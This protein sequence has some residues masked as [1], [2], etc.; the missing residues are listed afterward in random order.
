M[1]PLGG[2]PFRILVWF[3]IVVTAGCQ[4]V[5]R[6]FVGESTKGDLT[7]VARVSTSAL[8]IEW[9]FRNPR[10][11]P[12]LIATTFADEDLNPTSCVDLRYWKDGVL[13]LALFDPSP[14]SVRLHLLFPD[15]PREHEPC[16]FLLFELVPPRGTLTWTTTVALPV[17]IGRYGAAIEPVPGL[18]MG[19]VIPQFTALA[20]HTTLLQSR[21]SNLSVLDTVE[22]L[23]RRDSLLW[24]K[25]AWECDVKV[26]ETKIA[27]S[28]LKCEFEEPWPSVV[29]SAELN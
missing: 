9:T 1:R 29:C 19:A 16:R 4:A 17:H 12:V 8:K 23:E 22:I 21:E 26:V 24:V 27:I 7:A 6:T 28:A 25:R 13:T 20:L 3:S 2:F 10:D 15:V 5:E 11:V 14:S 18:R